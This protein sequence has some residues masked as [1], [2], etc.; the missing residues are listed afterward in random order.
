MYVFE[1]LCV[2]NGTSHDP[3]EG[4]CMIKIS[5][6]ILHQNSIFIKF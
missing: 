5:K 4:L 6:I 3:R 2:S 1:C